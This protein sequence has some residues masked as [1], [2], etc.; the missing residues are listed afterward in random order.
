MRRSRKTDAV[1][2]TVFRRSTSFRTWSRTVSRSEAL[3]PA[4]P[5]G[6]QTCRIWRIRRRP[7]CSTPSRCRR[8][9][10]KPDSARCMG[11]GNPATGPSTSS[12]SLRLK[13]DGTYNSGGYVRAGVAPSDDPR[14]APGAFHPLV[15]VHPDTGRRF[16]YLGR[17]RNAYIEGLSIA[18]SEALLD[19][20]WAHATAAPLTWSHSWHIGDLV[21]WDNRCT[22][23]RRNAFD[24][25]SRRIMHR[26]QIKA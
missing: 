19:E 13:H 9:A 1:S 4:R 8:A 3:A 11:R 15:G 17:R 25:G 12:P 21:V 22:M 18:D 7:A 23:H 16:L 10:V 14:T 26:T 20:I 5:S 2:S 24:P 6:T